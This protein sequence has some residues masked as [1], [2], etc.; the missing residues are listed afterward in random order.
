MPSVTISRVRSTPRMTRKLV[1]NPSAAAT[2]P[3]ATSAMTGSL[4]MPCSASKPAA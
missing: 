2:R 3:A 1:T 4:M